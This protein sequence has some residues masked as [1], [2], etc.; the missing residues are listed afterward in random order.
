M[1]LNSTISN[2]VTTLSGDS[3]TYATTDCFVASENAVILVRYSSFRVKIKQERTF[4]KKETTFSW[5]LKDGYSDGSPL[6][7]TINM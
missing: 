5:K 1:R 2:A 4:Q 7:V 3:S 6:T